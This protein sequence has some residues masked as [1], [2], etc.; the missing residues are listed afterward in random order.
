MTVIAIIIKFITLPGAYLKGFFEQV[1]CKICGCYV[2][3]DGYLRMDAACG[4]VDHIPAEKRGKAF[5]VAVFPGCVTFLFGIILWV[6]GLGALALLKIRPSDNVTMFVIYVI[7][8]YLGFSL[9]NNVFPMPEDAHTNWSLLF[10]K[11]NSAGFV[12]KVLLFIPSAIN[13]AGAY[14]ER[15]G[16]NFL[17]LSAASAAALILL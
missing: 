12:A 7:L 3:S 4:H 9:L 16:I 13:F 6:S 1:M 15:F 2:E 14:A 17:L 11:G 5:S 8:A 10:G